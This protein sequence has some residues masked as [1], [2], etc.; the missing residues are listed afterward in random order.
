M[1]DILPGPLFSPG[2][3][4]DPYCNLRDMVTPIARAGKEFAEQLWMQY[5]PYADANFLTEIRQ[6]FHARFW[7]MYLTCTLLQQSH[8][9]GYSI[10]CPKGKKAG[11]PDILVER[12]GLRIGIEAVTVSDGDPTKAD[13]VIRPELSRGY[14][15]PD[16]KIIGSCIASVH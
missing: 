15:V 7:E 8:Q 5:Y 10:S 4:E 3:A 12:D 16:E 2:E 11:G 9:Y 1:A 6:D 13:S 14:T